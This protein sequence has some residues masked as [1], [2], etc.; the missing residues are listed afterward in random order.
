MH[1]QG[2]KFPF[3]ASSSILL[4]GDYSTSLCGARPVVHSYNPSTGVLQQED[5]ES[6]HSLGYIQGSA[7]K[8]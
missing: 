2:I 3:S 5:C 7:S 8:Y 1:V 4:E 6:G